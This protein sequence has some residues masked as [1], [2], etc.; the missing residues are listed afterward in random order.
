MCSPVTDGLVYLGGSLPLRRSSNPESS[1]A[2]DFRWWVLGISFALLTL[3]SVTSFMTASVA[4]GFAA[5]YFCCTFVNG[6]HRL[7]ALRLC[8][9][10]CSSGTVFPS[11]LFCLCQGRYVNVVEI[12]NLDVLR[13]VSIYFT[14]HTFFCRV[15]FISFLPSTS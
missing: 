1:I 9:L 3:R 10:P 6:H 11:W 8:L 4:E 12:D 2:F 15:T 14:P 7:T 13:T 5:R